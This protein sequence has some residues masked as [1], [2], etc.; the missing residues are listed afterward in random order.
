MKK[1]ILL[2]VIIGYAGMS[3]GQKSKIDTSVNLDVLKSP[4]S[5]AFNL[6]GLSPSAIDRPTDLNAFAVSLQNST[7]NFS[8]LPNSYAVELAPAYFLQKKLI[9]LDKFNS[10]KFKDVFWQSFVLSIGY[11]HLGPEGQEEVDSLRQSKMGFGVKFSILRPKYS[12]ATQSTYN[13]LVEQQKRML[14]EWADNE[15]GNPSLNEANLIMDSIRALKMTEPD[16]ARQREKRKVLLTRLRSLNEA[17]N[18]ENNIHLANTEAF[19]ATKKIAADFKIE[20]IGAF[21]DFAA[22]MAL[23][24]PDDRFNNSRISKSGGW[25]TAGYD[26]GNK[27]ISI[28]G[29]ARYLFQPNQI[30]ADESNTLQT[31]N[32]STFDAGARL[33][34]TGVNGKFV[35]SSEGIYR[36]VLNK[37]VT[38]SSWRI[39]FNTEYDVGANKKLTFAFGRNFDGTISKGGNLIAALNF[40]SSFGSAR[41]ISD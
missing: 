26:S 22:G 7:K 17:I 21:I 16:T 2:M 12:K 4:S 13:N 15:A 31:K 18:D 28:L 19:E 6:L 3:F 39:V 41:K 33:L 14:K 9:S 27:G 38:N 37:N 5:P 40:I 32:I 29:I 11:T 20:R 25:L 8:S 23:D 35:L 10:V 36:S 34:L 1:I 30:F 24:F